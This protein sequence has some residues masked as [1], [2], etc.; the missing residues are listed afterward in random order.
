MK[1]RRLRRFLQIFLPAWVALCLLATLTIATGVRNGMRAIEDRAVSQSQGLERLLRVEQKFL[2]SDAL[3]LGVNPD[4]IQ[5]WDTGENHYLDLLANDYFTFLVSR[6][7][8]FKIMLAA[9]DGRVLLNV[10]GPEAAASYQAGKGTESREV[11]EQLATSGGLAAHEVL[12]RSRF[13][14]PAEGKGRGRDWLLEFLMPVIDG[15]GL[16]RGALMIYY[17]GTEFMRGVIKAAGFSGRNLYVFDGGG[18]LLMGPVEARG[19]SLDIRKL[20]PE[21]SRSGKGGFRQGGYVYAFTS[22]RPSEEGLRHSSGGGEV[23]LTSA[24]ACNQMSREQWKLLIRLPLPSNSEAVAPPLRRN[25]PWFVAGT[26]LLALVCWLLTRASLRRQETAR[27]RRLAEERLRIKSAFEHAAIGMAIVSLEGQVLETNQYFCRM[28]G[29][30]R[31]VVVWHEWFAHIEPED[32]K[33]IRSRM[34]LLLEGKAP[35]LQMELRLASPEG[36]QVWA[37]VTISLGKDAAGHPLHLIVHALDITENRNMAAEKEAMEAE[38]RQA[39]KL[40]AIGVLAGG[41]AHDFNNILGIIC[42]NAEVVQKNLPPGA[43][44]QLGQ[45][46]GRL[47]RAGE[48]GR[49]LVAQILNFCHPLDEERQVMFLS[50]AVEEAL[51]LLNASVPKNIGIE[52][53]PATPGPKVEATATEIQQVITNLCLNSSQAMGDLGGTVKVRT[54]QVEI[55]HAQ[56]AVGQRLEPGQWARLTVSDAGPGMDAETLDRIFDPFFTTKERGQGTGL[57]LATIQRIV[58]NLNGRIQ[59]E[60]RLGQG[61]TFH[62]YLH[63]S[64]KKPESKPRDGAAKSTPAKGRILLVDDETDYLEVMRDVLIQQGYRVEAADNS[65]RAWDIFQSDPGSFAALV[66]DQHMS[67]LSGTDLAGMATKL[68]PD[69]PVILCSGSYHTLDAEE[70]VSH[71]V[72]RVLRKPFGINQLVEALAQVLAKNAENR[73]MVG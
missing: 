71:G 70:V 61:S 42:A 13:E 20:W 7:G 28:L 22:Y 19:G 2:I 57:G 69:L 49:N 63:L 10:D 58:T 23:L 6:P 14:D 41:I 72:Q 45:C 51:K 40:E 31:E 38:L 68:S 53:R 47:L 21:I 17:S 12:M 5:F 4:L 11:T 50:D 9:K 32:E 15:R 54:E 37:L 48:R 26:L 73:R 43:T 8:M 56:A 25:M 36:R 24:T 44:P 66:T 29:R 16:H 35:Y 67:R 46:L 33:I 65:A 52:F 64:H 34:P 27:A 1:R 39:Q 55:A 62:I 18:G 60:S 3:I 59:V 30:S